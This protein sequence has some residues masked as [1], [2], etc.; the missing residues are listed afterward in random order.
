[1]EFVWLAGLGWS[2]AVFKT[3]FLDF[4]SVYSALL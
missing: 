4:L 1:M 3:L 2:F